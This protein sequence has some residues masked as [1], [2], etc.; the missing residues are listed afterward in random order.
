MRIADTGYWLDDIPS[1]HFYDDTLAGWLSNLLVVGMGKVNATCADMGCGEGKY[2]ATIPRC[3]GFD[4]NPHAK[5]SK[6]DIVDLTIPSLMVGTY[7]LVLCL[8]VGEKIP[9]RYTEDF[10]HNLTWS[11]AASGLLVL[12]WAIPGQNGRGNINCLSN[13]AV[14]ALLETHN[15][16][17]RGVLSESARS[18]ATLPWFKSSLMVFG[19]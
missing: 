7:D 17:L 10:L 1:A 14:A 12:S 8:S 18:A 11:V 19:Q 16:K 3:I 2:V 5:Q 13:V 15:F 4:G 9:L 6:V